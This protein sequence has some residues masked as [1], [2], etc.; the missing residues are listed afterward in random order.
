MFCIQAETSARPRSR[1]R[2]GAGRLATV[3]RSSARWLCCNTFC[4]PFACS[5]GAARQHGVRV[6]IRTVSWQHRPHGTSARPARRSSSAQH[7]CPLACSRA[8]LCGTA[9]CMQQPC[10]LA[11]GSGGCM[12]GAHPRNGVATPRR[13]THALRSGTAVSCR[14]QRPDTRRRR[15]CCWPRLP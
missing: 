15:Q 7:I 8:A 10:R 6:G 3:L 11:A 5:C 12:Q 1:V 2:V 14:C 13:Q 9:P 4:R